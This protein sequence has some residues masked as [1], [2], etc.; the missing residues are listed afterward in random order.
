MSLTGNIIPP[1]YMLSVDQRGGVDGTEITS[2]GSKGTPFVLISRVDV[3]SYTDGQFLF[4]LYRDGLIND[5]VG[6]VPVVQ[7]GYDTVSFGYHCQ[8]LD[9]R[10]LSCQR[11]PVI[12]GGLQFTSGAILECEW[13]L[14]AIKD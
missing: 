7:S 1:G 9:V 4:K 12:V 13:T 14:I 3:E 5:S 8:V 11:A 6:A 10:L 2:E